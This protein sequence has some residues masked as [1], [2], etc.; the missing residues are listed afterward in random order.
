MGVCITGTGSYLPDFILTNDMLA[1]IVETNDEW[2]TER[3]G[4]KTRHIAVDDTTTDM[5]KRASLKALSASGTDASEIELI[6][7]VSVSSDVVVPSGAGCLQ[8]ELEIPDCMAFDMNANC[9]GFIF[10]LSCADA[11]MKAN[12]FKKA[13]VVGVERLSKI[14]DW[15]DRSTCILLG[16]GAGA[17]VLENKEGT[18]GIKYI[19]AS[20]KPDE[21]GLLTCKDAY[22]EN[23]FCKEASD[24]SFHM[25]GQEVFKFATTV[26]VSEIKTLCEKNGISPADITAVVPHQANIRIL[27]YA[28]R[29]LGMEKE[30]FFANV[31]EVGNTSSASIPIALDKFM[32]TKAPQKG[33]KIVLVGFGGG[34][35]YGSALIQW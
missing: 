19:H 32:N 13:L 24:Y 5:A 9:T 28:A 25:E 34:L 18:D 4:I 30:K 11:L 17:V 10:A 1:Q 2:I 7:L 14:V 20:G 21:A 16:D 3:T 27:D 26:M 22:R 12:G 35:T 15:A 6:I 33:D 31:G 23:P 29:K 8:R